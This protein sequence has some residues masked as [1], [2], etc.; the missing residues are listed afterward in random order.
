[1]NDQFPK[2]P[3]LPLLRCFNPMAASMTMHASTAS[4]TAHS[5]HRTAR[6]R[7]L[8]TGCD[9]CPS[10]TTWICVS[11]G[12]AYWSVVVCY[13]CA[14]RMVVRSV[15]PRRSWRGCG[16]SHTTAIAQ[17]GHNKLSELPVGTDH[18]SAQPGTIRTPASRPYDDYPAISAASSAPS[19]QQASRSFLPGGP[20]TVTG[21][22][23]A[24]H[25]RPVVIDSTARTA[26][27]V[28]IPPCTYR[29]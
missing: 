23:T 29:P 11:R 3:L 17:R 26:P 15:A 5:N 7:R 14:S 2:T 12:A 19:S 13:Y 1:M 27:V 10:L 8:P 18:I 24:R 4:T 25:C 20:V 16:R 6:C 22:R 9:P 28:S 21:G